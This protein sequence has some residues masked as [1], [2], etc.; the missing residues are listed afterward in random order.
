MAYRLPYNF[1][2]I[3]YKNFSKVDIHYFIPVYYLQDDL[4]YIESALNELDNRIE[5]IW[6]QIRRGVPYAWNSDKVD[7]YHA[8]LTPQPYTVP[9]A[10]ADGTLDPN[11]IQISMPTTT[12]IKL[13][14]TS[15]TWQVPEGVNALF[16]YACGGGGG[17]GKG[18]DCYYAVIYGG[19]GGGGG[20]GS[21]GGDK[22]AITQVVP[23]ETLIITI[24]AG[25]AGGTTGD[26]GRGGSTTV[27]GSISGTLVTAYGGRG[28]KKG[29]DGD[30][31]WYEGKIIPGSGGSGGIIS[32]SWGTSG[33]MGDDGWYFEGYSL[34]G[35]GGNGGKSVLVNN[36]AKGGAGATNTTNAQPGED[37]GTGSGGGGG[38]GGAKFHIYGA[39]GG[40]GGNGFVV[41]LG[42]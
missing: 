15:T 41:I 21:S 33:N 37:G 7:G 22:L 10:R 27:V 35:S 18:G 40:N 9:V 30:Y 13:F 26:G 17:G 24:G 4:D 29:G 36:V 25:G 23:G 3:D 31:D 12:L 14:T 6:D 34:G 11:W 8:S 5:E 39:P 38:G 1:L 2:S 32:T 16:I 28:G 42:G 20:G 19:P